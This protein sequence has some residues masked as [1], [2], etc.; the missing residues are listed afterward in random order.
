[1]LLATI[2]IALAAGCAAE[3]REPSLLTLSRS[4]YERAFAAAC[5]VVREEGLAPE[6]A[7]RRTGLIETSPR[8]AGSVVE[9]WAWRD[10]TAAD[11]AEATFGFERRRARIEFV[12]A[13]FPAAAPDA[14]APLAGAILPGS[15]RGK[16]AD[17]ES[18]VATDLD[19]LE[20]RVSVSVERQFR[21]GYQGS[22]YTRAFS[23]FS[24]DVTVKDDGL[25]PRD[26]STWTPVA[27]DERLERLLVARIRDEMARDAASGA[28]AMRGSTNR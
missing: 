19:A 6:I 20:L 21:P 11:V 15:E 14:S 4:Q 17:L 10:M 5:E 8:L 22:A 23:S 16:G 13:R 24:R 3:R 12:P 26:R 1:M 2:L 27:R 25:A 9:P 18:P 7:D 28:Q